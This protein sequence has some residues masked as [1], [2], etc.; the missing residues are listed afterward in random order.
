MTPSALA[1][2]LLDWLSRPA[3]GSAARAGWAES[4]TGLSGSE[5][6]PWWAAGSYEGQA[7]HQLLRLRDHPA[8]PALMPWL[9]A[10]IPL[11]ETSMPGLSR[12]VLVPVPSWK[13]H[14]NPLPALLAGALS[15]RLGWALRPE[16]L[17]RSRPV[18]GQHHLG[19]QLRLAN[20]EGAFLASAAGQRPLAPRQPLL[21]VDDILTTGATAGAAATA[22]SEAGWRVS[23]L[24]CLARTPARRH[25]GRDLRSTSRQGD[26]PG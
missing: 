19:R 14:S 11:L 9:Q 12:P 2:S 13:R 21:L 5:P 15:R 4:L 20:Q 26:K 17:R 25:R 16:L 10:L 1:G 23:G 22:L 3:A 8:Q 6:L 18:L 24:V 7:R